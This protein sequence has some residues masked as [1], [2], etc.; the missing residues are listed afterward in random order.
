MGQ[1]G[2]DVGGLSADLGWRCPARGLGSCSP[3]VLGG[4]GAPKVIASFRRAAPGLLPHPCRL[5]ACLSPVH[6]GCPCLPGQAACLSSLLTSHHPG[7]PQLTLASPSL[8][9]FRRP[10]PPRRHMPR[11]TAHLHARVCPDSTSH[12]SSDCECMS[13][14]F[15]GRA[16][17][18]CTPQRGR[19]L[20]AWVSQSLLRC[21]RLGFVLLTAGPRTC[22]HEALG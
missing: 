16:A 9:A 5:A 17:W 1:A 2:P 19:R 4:R 14:L 10:P 7:G 13:V 22:L 21:S 11:F 3:G 18:T 6:L 12:C 20:G 15:S 8:A